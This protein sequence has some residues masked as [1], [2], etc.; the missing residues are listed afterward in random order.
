[1]LGR[2]ARAIL[3]KAARVW[4]RRRAAARWLGAKLLGGTRSRPLPGTPFRVHFDG[5]RNAGLAAGDLGAHE[6]AE[7]ECARRLLAGRPAAAVW[8]VGANVGLWS[9]WLSAVAPAAEL[10]AFEPDPANLALLRLNRER[11]GLAWAIRPV[12]LSDREGPAPF[13]TDPVTGATGSVEAGADWIGRHYGAGREVATAELTTIDAE[14]SRGARP[15]DLLKI[16]VEG[17]ELAVLRGGLGTLRA[18]RPALI[19]EV[20]ADPDGVGAL[21]A[22]LGYRLADAHGNQ[23]GRPAYYTVALPE[24]WGR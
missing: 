20:T 8:D 5:F 10:R 24:E 9:L 1:M 22:G 4:L 12:G 15:P 16:D 11:N 6:R 13:Y 23:I 2:I 17:H 18:H 21:L 14:V 19:V 3:P 7:R